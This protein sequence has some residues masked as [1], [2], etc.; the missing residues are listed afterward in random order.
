MRITSNIFSPV[1]AAPVRRK[2]VLRTA[3]GPVATVSVVAVERVEGEGQETMARWVFSSPIGDP[4]TVAAGGLTVDGFGGVGWTRESAV[5]LRVDHAWEIAAGQPWAN[6]AGADG[7]VGA[8]G[9]GL[10]AGAGAV[11]E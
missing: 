5:A 3:G 2:R 6:V 8:G 10:A 11:G 4:A 9:E 7:I 1:R